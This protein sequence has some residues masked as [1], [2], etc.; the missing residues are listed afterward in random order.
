MTIQLN[1][2]KTHFFHFTQETSSAINKA[3]HSKIVNSNINWEFLNSIISPKVGCV[4][5]AGVIGIAGMQLSEKMLKSAN[6]IAHLVGYGSLLVTEVAT[7]IIL[8][9]ATANIFNTVKHQAKNHREILTST[10]IDK[11]IKIKASLDLLTRI[12]ATGLISF[13]GLHSPSLLSGYSII[14]RANV[15]DKVEEGIKGTQ[16]AMNFL[17]GYGDEPEC[18][19]VQASDRAS[20]IKLAA[21]KIF[22]LF[23]TTQLI[24]AFTSFNTNSSSTH[25]VILNSTIAGIVSLGFDKGLEIAQNYR[26]K[27]RVDEKLNLLWTRISNSLQKVQPKKT[28]P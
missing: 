12:T 27:N 15:V 28:H 18:I 10:Q 4:E 16:I 17:T 22:T 6:S 8:I 9:K 21:L 3:I 25:Q 13:F 2:L 1:L 7:A 14:G 5:I 19:Q 24:G 20:Q 26:I 11:R 23:A